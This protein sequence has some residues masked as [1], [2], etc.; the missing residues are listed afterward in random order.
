MK[1]LEYIF[2]WIGAVLVL[3]VLLL[4]WGVDHYRAKASAATTAL[5]QL[6]ADVREQNRTAKKTLDRLTA[7]RDQAQ[8]DLKQ[9]RHL[10]ER[11]DEAAK[12]E[13]A[14]LGGELER[15]PWRVRVITTPGACGPGG[16]G[17]PG[18]VAPALNAGAADPAE[19]YGLLPA[20]NSRR[21]GELSTEAETINAAY[22]SCRD[23]LFHQ[24]DQQ[25]DNDK[26]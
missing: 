5:Q 19:T 7:E 20:R 21:L 15:R 24:I 18:A 23:Q 26:P 12:Q 6:Q 4:S 3:L 9:F 2:R 14:R 25:I 10:Q 8:A 1:F 22:R 13:I 17:A 16:G 11:T